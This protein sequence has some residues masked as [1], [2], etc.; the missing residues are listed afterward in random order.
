VATLWRGGVQRDPFLAVPDDPTRDTVDRV[1][2]I[3]TTRPGVSLRGLEIHEPIQVV[4]DRAGVRDGRGSGTTEGFQPELWT[5]VTVPV[6]ISVG[7][8]GA[9]FPM[10]R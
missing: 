10:A 2:A 4:S 8:R 9:R 5:A 7:D 3:A 6:R 1:V